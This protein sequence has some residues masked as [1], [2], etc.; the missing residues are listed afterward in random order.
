MEIICSYRNNKPLRDSFNAL[1]EKTFG[2]NFEN[3]YQNG[4][5]VEKYNPYSMV[6][7]GTVIANVSVNQCDYVVNGVR[8]RFIQLGTVMTDEAYRNQGLIRKIMERIDEDYKG[9]VD[10]IFLFGG[11]DVIDFYPK[12]G[13]EKSKEFAYTKTVSVEKTATIENIP[14]QKKE[15]WDKLQ[16]A[17][18]EATAYSSFEPVGYSEL[19]LFYITGF[20]QENVFY[21]KESDAYVI[22]EIEDD[23]L[24]LHGIFARKPVNADD[25]INAFGSSIKKV[26][27]TYV[28]IDEEGC[29]MEEY[30]EEDC[31]LFLKGEGF[32]DFE[33]LK[34][35]FAAL[36]HA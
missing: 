27:F 16:K 18:E 30:H 19:F 15:D 24:I 1:A 14:M 8:K 3:W 10:G 21:H 26:I 13:F 22:A 4:Y 25:V 34:V 9:K 7:D 6:E 17:I 35:R 33:D 32:K 12:F 20:M 36:G 5:W 28:P 11:D 31:T 29:A 23:T 2:L